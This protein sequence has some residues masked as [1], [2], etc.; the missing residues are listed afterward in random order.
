[1]KNSHITLKLLILIIANDIGDS[2]AQLFLKK[3]FLVGGMSSVGFA[4]IGEFVSRNIGSPWV[5]LGLFI[6]MMNFF[7]WILILYR[8]D[9]SIAM[10]VSSTSYMIIPFLAIFFLHEHVSPIRWAGIILIAAGI[11]FVLKSPKVKKAGALR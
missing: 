9:L 3:G 7:I 6:Y 4:D 1:M 10:P 8:V 5:W 2:I 11:Y